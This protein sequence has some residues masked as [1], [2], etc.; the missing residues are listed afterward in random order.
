MSLYFEN[1]IN[2]VKDILDT[3]ERKAGEVANATM[4]EVRTAM[5]IG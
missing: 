3:G 2:E 1:N 4:S 5:K